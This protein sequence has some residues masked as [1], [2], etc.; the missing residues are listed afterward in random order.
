MK[1]DRAIAAILACCLAAVLGLG[2]WLLRAAR[3]SPPTPLAE[4]SASAGATATATPP[5]LP[6]AVRGFRLAGT[7]VGDVVYAIIE[8]SDG[9]NTL[10]QPGQIVSGLGQIVAIG[11]D[12]IT[13]EADGHQ[14]ELALS[15]A[16]TA[17]EAPTSAV[18]TPTTPARPQ[19]DPSGSEPSP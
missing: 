17:T 14:F 1:T 16:P 15:A 12:H 19:R 13:V 2:F 7:V 5:A 3:E 11:D 8:T 10:V 18:A 4:P 6:A 9:G